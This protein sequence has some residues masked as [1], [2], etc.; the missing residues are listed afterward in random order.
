MTNLPV[1]VPAT[2]QP[3]SL[4]TGALWNANVANG[5]TFSTNVPMFYGY[6][7]AAQSLTN[8]AAAAITLDSST[9]DTYAGHSNS[10]NNS[11]Y[12]AQIPG[13][14]LVSGTVV[15]GPNATAGRGATIYKNGTEVLGAAGFSAGTTPFAS[16][17]GMCLVYLNGTGDYVELWGYQISTTTLATSA[18]HLSSMLCL[19][20]HA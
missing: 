3:G 15:F 2:V 5:I 8:N 6:Q 20:V 12:V 14:Y 11:R 7:S 4:I 19:W 18:S 13:W 16:A 9:I 1:P 10:S 17:T